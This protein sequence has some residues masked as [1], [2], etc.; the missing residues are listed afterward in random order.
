MLRPLTAAALL[1]LAALSAVAQP[2]APE[3]GRVF[4]DTRLPTVHLTIHPDSL[5]AILDRDNAFTDLEYR[6]RF[7]WDDGL[8]RDTVEEIGLKLKGF[9]SRVAVKR[10]FKVSFNT[11]RPGREWEGLDKLN[12]NGE[13]NDPT[14]IR[15]KMAWEVF[16]ASRVHAAREGFVQLFINDEDFGVYANVEHFDEEFLS[17]HFRDPDGSL[18]K[19]HYPA[20]LDY[21]GDDPAIYRDLAPFGRPSYEL[22]QGEDRYEE[23]VAFIAALNLPT[24]DELPDALEPHLDVNGFLRALAVDVLT[25]NWDSYAWGQNNFFLYFD[26]EIDRFRYLPFD[27]DNTFGIDFAGI[28]WG[29]RN[30]YAWADGDPTG[31]P[32][33]PL[34]KRL[35]QVPDYRDRF[36]FYLRGLAEDVFT[37]EALFPQMD[38][39]RDLIDEAIATDPLRGGDYGWSMAD[40]YTSFDAPLG[41]HV[42]Y[43]LKPFVTMRRQSALAQVD[44]VDVAPLIS[45]LRLAEP[46]PLPGEA[47]T[48]RAW[49][50]DEDEPREVW[51][52]AET[53]GVVLL[54]PM[55]HEG[56][57]VYATTMGPFEAGA[58]VRYHVEAVDARGQTRTE[59]RGGAAAPAS[60]TVLTVAEGGAG[61]VVNEVLA[62]NDAVVADEFGEFDDWIE[63]YNASGEAR[64]L[65]G[66]FITDDPAEPDKFALPD[67]TVAAGGFILLWADDDDE[68]QGPL[69]TSFN[70]DAAN[71]ES[72]SLFQS[73]GEGGFELV[74]AIAFGPQTTD[75]SLGRITDGGEALSRFADPT[76]GASNA[77]ATDTEPQPG[78]DALALVSAHPNPFRDVVTLTLTLPHPARLTLDVFDALGRR[79]GTMEQESEAGTARLRWTGSLPTGTYLAR[80]RAE[81]SSGGTESAT[82]RVTVVR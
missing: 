70:L 5:A 67:T 78:A 2:L 6:A 79:L 36:S 14:M 50:E 41:G 27:L 48:V 18:F 44:R 29:T 57:G 69:H 25:A 53:G 10:S 71:G 55:T 68:D 60:V 58:T 46:Q 51:L 34:A 61:F 52:H 65:A 1:G 24:L 26:P 43:G 32:P 3:A 40:F 37:E 42:P 82:R 54:S 17:A 72:A 66:L 80:V 16:R 21:L 19:S 75:I 45:D 9:T 31:D 64:S 56:D 11:F 47:V 15:A 7:V 33:R 74:S 59:P 28:D 76:P 73:D 38:A 30:P 49:V 22:V 20:D 81:Y 4:D 23:L 62:S 63:L 13:H 77:T 8:A 35:L 39:L 12:L